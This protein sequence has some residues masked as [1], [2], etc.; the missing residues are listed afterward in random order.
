[1][2]TSAQAEESGN[3][4]AG[5]TFRGLARGLA[6]GLPGWGSVESAGCTPLAGCGQLDAGARRRSSRGGVATAS[7]P[8][9]GFHSL[10]FCV[11]NSMLAGGGDN[12]IDDCSQYSNHLMR[13]CRFNISPRIAVSSC[14]TFRCAT[15]CLHHP[16]HTRSALLCNVP[17]AR[18]VG[19]DAASP[20]PSGSSAGSARSPINDTICAVDD[21]RSVITDRRGW[22]A[23]TLCSA[24]WSML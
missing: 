22:A 9:D 7:T 13:C 6:C 21:Q 4:A 1:M 5:P 10:L 2:S 11:V 15:R 12:N 3:G 18:R 23:H 16:I 14:I 20:S 8:S 17:T 19:A 24:A